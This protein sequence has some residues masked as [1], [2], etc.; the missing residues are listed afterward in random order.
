MFVETFIFLK[1]NNNKKCS[2]RIKYNE[3][4]YLNHLRLNIRAT[5]IFKTCRKEIITVHAL[6]F[7]GKNL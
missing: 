5:D 4:I 6:F 3:S 7:C 1:I 2:L